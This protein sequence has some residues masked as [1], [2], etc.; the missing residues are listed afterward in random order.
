MQN[1]NLVGRFTKPVSKR[2]YKTQQGTNTV[3]SGTIAVK[4][5]RYNREKGER[6]TTFIN[7]QVWG[8]KAETIAKYTAQGSLIELSGEFI[9]NNFTDKKGIDRY[10]LVFEVD[11]FEL[12]ETK[13]ET[14]KRFKEQQQQAVKN[15]PK[16]PTAF[17]RIGQ[18]AIGQMDSYGVIHDDY[19]YQGQ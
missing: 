2:E 16:E 15:Q 11:D 3:A 8:K 1:I 13:E 5:K 4:R 19:Y 9:N 7:F 17:D 10:E 14:E 6:P 12:L 18:E